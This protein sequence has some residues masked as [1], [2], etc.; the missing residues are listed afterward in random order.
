MPDPGSL[1]DFWV[2]RG[3]L[4]SAAGVLGTEDRDVQIRAVEGTY[5]HMSELHLGCEAEK[6]LIDISQRL[7][8]MGVDSEIADTRLTC[9]DPIFC[10][11]V[12]VDVTDSSPSH[13]HA[14]TSPQPSR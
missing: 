2:R 7:A 4:E 12:V 14:I 11:R 10:H 13:S 6:D 5:R 1:T 3:M 9:V 8:D